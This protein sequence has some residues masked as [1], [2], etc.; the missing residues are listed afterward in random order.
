MKLPSLDHRPQP[1]PYSTADVHAASSP[2]AFNCTRSCVKNTREDTRGG[3]GGALRNPTTSRGLRRETV[4]AWG[5]G[6][7]PWVLKILESP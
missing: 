3:N 5:R 4:G 7:C 1:F 2:G 6:W